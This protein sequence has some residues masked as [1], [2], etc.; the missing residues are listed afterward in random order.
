[1]LTNNELEKLEAKYLSKIYASLYANLDNILKNLLS[2]NK[3]LYSWKNKIKLTKKKKKNDKEDGFDVGAERVIYSVLQRASD[4]G[5]PNSSPVASD[6]FFENDEAFINIDCKTCQGSTNLGDHWAHSIST[7]QT[8]Y[9][10]FMN[11]KSGKKIIG[12]RYYEPSLDTYYLNKPNLTYFITILYAVEKEYSIVNLNVAC[13]PNG[14][15]VEVYGRSPL[16]PGKNPP[17]GRF[18]QEQCNDFK[19]V[20]GKRIKIVHENLNNLD[21]RTAKKLEKEF[22]SL[23]R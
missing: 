15:L 13:M 2:M 18:A 11:I 10:S 5:E 19:I 1:M 4:L 17:E 20:G 22:L 21:L 16:R 6:L 14:Q 12:E 23:I 8:S 9:K 7:N 3:L